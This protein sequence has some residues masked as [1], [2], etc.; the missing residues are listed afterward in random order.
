MGVPRFTTPTFLLTLDDDE[1][2][3]RLA[4]NVFVTF[5]SGMNEITKSG[6]SLE[7]G[8]KTV[9]VF[10]EQEDTGKFQ[11]DHVFIQINWMIGN[12]RC[13]S[14]IVCHPISDQL[15]RRVI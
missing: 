7:V 13:S 2:D 10:L 1:V 15:L 5:T 3:L 11:A 9:S 12:N 8:E 6:E 4:D 14:E